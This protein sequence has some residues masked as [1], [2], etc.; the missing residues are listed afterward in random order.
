MCVLK[1][2]T[3]IFVIMQDFIFHDIPSTCVYE[4]A[5]TIWHKIILQDQVKRLSLIQKT[6]QEQQTRLIL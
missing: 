5:L 6:N 1:Y 3:F 2:Y 4:H